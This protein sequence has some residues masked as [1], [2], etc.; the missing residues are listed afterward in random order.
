MACTYIVI[1]SAV[2]SKITLDEKLSG[3]NTSF[4]IA[5]LQ[6]CKVL[7]ITVTGH[8]CWKGRRAVRN[9]VLESKNNQWHNS[10]EPVKG[11]PKS[12]RWGPGTSP[13]PQGL[14]KT[15]PYESYEW[16]TD[17]EEEHIRTKEAGRFLHY[18]TLTSS[19]W[20]NTAKSWNRA[21][22]NIS[23]RRWMSQWK[24]PLLIK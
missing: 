11:R 8:C 6:H 1:K 14:T 3:K 18:F 4:C 2:S 16:S 10:W 5:I 17:S 20:A 15:A 9:A 23:P 19:D 7:E 13:A 24:G 21:R 12:S 22:L